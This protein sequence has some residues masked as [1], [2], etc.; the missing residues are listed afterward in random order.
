MLTSRN[1]PNFFA[2]GSISERVQNKNSNDDKNKK[3]LYNASTVYNPQG[4][5]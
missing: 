3:D 1:I 5:R 4:V 2:L